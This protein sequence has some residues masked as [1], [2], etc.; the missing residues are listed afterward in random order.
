MTRGEFDIIRHH[1]S[2]LANHAGGVVCGIG[3]DAAVLEVPAGQELVVTTDT[4][5]A[6]VHFPV[7][8]NAADIGYKALAVNLSDIAAMAARPQW[9]TLALTLPEYDPVWLDAFCSGF[10]ELAKEFGIS[11][12]GGDTTRGPLSITIQVMGIAAAGTSVRRGGASPGDQIYVTGSLGGA[13]LA[14]HRMRAGDESAGGSGEACLQRLLRPQPRVATGLLLQG[15]ASAAID[16]S[17]GM[18]AD[19]MHLLNA[20]G[21]GAV[22]HLESI[23][24][25][26]ELA[27]LDEEEYW[28]MALC[29]GDDYELCF[30]V[31]AGRQA[32]IDKLKAVSPVR[33]S[34]IGAITSAGLSWRRADGSEL[35]LPAN[36][37]RHF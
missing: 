36:G 27:T 11:L 21:T 3:D 23:P 28:R 12:V 29:A 24:V 9:V 22:I 2:R 32:A 15:I 37:Y 6:G 26:P 17:D 34:H 8:T 20:S 1:F 19:L 7:N 31:P 16:I 18:A 35:Q 5:V 25:D 10:A 14:L 13:G 30:T 4:L 33:I